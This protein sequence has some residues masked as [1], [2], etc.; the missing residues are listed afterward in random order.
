[1]EKDPTLKGEALEALLRYAL[2]PGYVVRWY[3]SASMF[4]LIMEDVDA[5]VAEWSVDRDVRAAAE[6]MR[7]D[8]AGKGQALP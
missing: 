8:V 1:M 6:R 7:D 3:T 2:D 5:F 4:R